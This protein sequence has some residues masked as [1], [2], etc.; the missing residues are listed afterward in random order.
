MGVGTR[1]RDIKTNIQTSA[2]IA[3]NNSTVG[4]RNEIS[5]REWQVASTA[6]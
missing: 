5:V 6:L 3:S 2:G 1:R 4:P